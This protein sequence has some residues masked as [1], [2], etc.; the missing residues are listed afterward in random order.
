M[1]ARTYMQPK[2]T[3]MGLK[4]SYMWP[5][6]T[7]MGLR[8]TYMGLKLTF[9]GL[10]LSHMGHNLSYMGLKLR[11]KGP[12]LTHMALCSRNFQNVKL[13]LDFV[14][15]WW[16]YC[17]SNFTWREIKFQRIQTV[18]PKMILAIFRRS[19]FWFFRKSEQLLSPKFTKILSS[20]SL[21]LP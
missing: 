19:E 1:F 7:H 2:L 6:L 5:E 10:K 14:G 8:L 20:A 18:D 15:I 3:Y 12:K 9:I 11:Y 21:I 17:H 4:L 16:F 13:R